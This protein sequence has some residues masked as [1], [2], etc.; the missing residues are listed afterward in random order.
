M[1]ERV[2]GFG[3]VAFVKNRQLSL[4]SKT[5]SVSLCRRP[6]LIFFEILSEHKVR[7]LKKDWNSF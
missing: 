2:L 1:L 4:E 3:Q 6:S 7:G 5:I